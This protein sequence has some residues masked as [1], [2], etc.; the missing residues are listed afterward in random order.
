MIKI[1][2]MVI[3]CEVVTSCYKMGPEED[4]PRTVP[5]TNNPHA[6]PGPIPSAP[7]LNNF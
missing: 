7:L 6:M 3:L 1:I 5:V 4:D 2:I